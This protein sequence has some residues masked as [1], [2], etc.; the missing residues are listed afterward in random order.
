MIPG[1][2]SADRFAAA[3]AARL[4]AVVPSGLSVRAEGTDVSVYDPALAGGS[5][6]ARL[7]TEED[8]RPIGEL[9]RLAAYGILDATQDVVMESTREQWPMGTTRAA[10]PG[11]RVVGDRLDLWFGD[12]DKPV[13]RLESVDLAELAHGAA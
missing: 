10:D 13:L 12:E 7:L 1:R 2:L 4:N 11:A 5:A 3:L 6:A 8:G 9:V